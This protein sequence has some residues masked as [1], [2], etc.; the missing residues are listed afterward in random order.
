MLNKQTADWKEP[1]CKW[2]KIQTGHKQIWSESF[3]NYENL[4]FSF[5]LWPH[6]VKLLQLYR[7]ETARGETGN[8]GTNQKCSMLG[9]QHIYLRQT[10]V[11][12]VDFSESLVLALFNLSRYQQRAFKFY[13][14]QLESLISIRLLRFQNNPI[15]GINQISSKNFLSMQ[16]CCLSICR[17]VTDGI[18]GFDQIF[19]M[20]MVLLILFCQNKTPYQIK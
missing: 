1:Y 19:L 5:W 13:Q 15:N 12:K 16:T 7:R 3:D 20:A 14:N 2:H 8:Y 17:P 11:S 10:R 9:D 6:C 18:V 4:A